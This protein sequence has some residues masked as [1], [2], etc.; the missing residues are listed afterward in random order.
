M[1]Q[2]KCFNLGRS[3][4]TWEQVRDRF[5]GSLP[6]IS[7]LAV[8][9]DAQDADGDHWVRLPDLPTEPT[10]LDVDAVP[11]ATPFYQGAVETR[12]ASDVQAERLERIATAALQGWLASPN[13]AR[14]VL[15][16]EMAQQS[17]ACAKALIAELDKEPH[18][19]PFVGEV[20]L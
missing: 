9:E 15:Y 13:T 18:P 16:T 7:S 14:T 17:V 5:P 4:Y 10:A 20:G 8:G 1:K 19:N 2:F 6:A 11:C 3:P 12:L